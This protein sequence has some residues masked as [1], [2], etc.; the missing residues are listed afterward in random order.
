MFFS[1]TRRRP[2]RNPGRRA[3]APSRTRLLVEPLEARTVPSG[4]YVFTTLAEAPGALPDSTLAYGINDSGQIVGS[5]ADPHVHG[6]LLSDGQYTTI[7][8]PLSGY[9]QAYGINDSGQIVGYYGGGYYGDDSHYHGFLFSGGQYTTIDDPNAVPGTIPYGINN[10]GQIVG[11]YRDANF[12]EHGFLLSDGQYTTI[13]AP[14]AV[15][16]MRLNGINDSGQIVGFYLDAHFVFHSFLFSGGQYTTIEV[17]H[18]H[19]TIASGINDSGQIVGAY[20]GHG[21][22]LSGGQYTTIDVPGPLFTVPKGINAA[23]QIVGLY[24]DAHVNLHSFLATPAST[25]PSV[26]CSV[27]ASQLWP[28]NHQLVNVGLG[29]TVDPADA[30]LQVQV[31]ANDGAVPADAADIGP[32]TLRLRAERQGNGQGRVYLIVVTAT[33]G[34][35]TAFDVCTVVVPHDQSAGSLAQ[36]QAAAAAAEA[37]Y[38]QFQTAPPSFHLLGSGPT[39]PAGPRSP[40]VAAGIGAGFRFAPAAVVSLGAAPSPSPTPRTTPS[41]GPTGHVP[42]GGPAA[43]VAGYLAPAD[44]GVSRFALLGLEEQGGGEADSWVPDLWLSDRLFA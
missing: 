10:R 4:G 14:N 35:Q 9:N 29:V 40:A 1:N 15:E 41:T 26:T 44:E 3:R 19:Y 6:F 24:T 28:P 31:Y 36:V 38:R 8:D 30:S 5:Y 22:L 25:A 33:A 27:A 43:P 39:A 7:D 32:G 34:G 42:A 12:L 11:F 21:F 13:D 16:A 37:H 23:G 17:P 2:S 20:D 18:A